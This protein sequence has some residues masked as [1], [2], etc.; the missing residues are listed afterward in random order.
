MY[1]N[2]RTFAN[3]ARANNLSKTPPK[4]HQCVNVIVDITPNYKL[5]SCRKFVRNTPTD[6]DFITEKTMEYELTQI[7]R[8]DENKC[9]IQGRYYVSEL[10]NVPFLSK[11]NLQTQSLVASFKE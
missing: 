5:Y 11:H 6:I 4:C 3:M 10:W 1:S 7:A 2:F 8:S 9:G